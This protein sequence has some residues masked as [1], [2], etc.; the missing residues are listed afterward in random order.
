MIT[1]RNVDNIDILEIKAS[2]PSIFVYDKQLWIGVVLLIDNDHQDLKD[3][4]MHPAF[5]AGASTWRRRDDTCFYLISMIPA[6][7]QHP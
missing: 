5:L 3:K 6:E 1:G 7:F 2:E 4:F